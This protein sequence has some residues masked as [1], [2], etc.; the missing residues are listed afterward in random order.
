MNECFL[1]SFLFLVLGIPTLCIV[2]AGQV[3]TLPLSV[4]PILLIFLNLDNAI[5]VSLSVLITFLLW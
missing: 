1:P 2:Y 4:S 5:S 3:S